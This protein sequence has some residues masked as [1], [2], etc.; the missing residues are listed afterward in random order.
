MPTIT[1]AIESFVVSPDK[2]AINDKEIG[3][4]L[5]VEKAQL[6]GSSEFRKTLPLKDMSYAR[7]SQ[8][9]PGFNIVIKTKP[10][11]KQGMLP[12][13]FTRYPLVGPE[14]DKVSHNETET[15]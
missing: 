13:E 5:Q 7:S 2:D 14:S 6:R 10:N 1:P 3:S 4:I 8:L 12:S 11:V 9:L 15:V